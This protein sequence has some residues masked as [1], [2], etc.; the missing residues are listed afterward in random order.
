MFCNVTSLWTVMSHSNRRNSAQDEAGTPGGPD[1]LL[2]TWHAACDVATLSYT[3]GYITSVVKE[4]NK[5]DSCVYMYKC[6]GVLGRNP[7][8]L[9]QFLII[10][11]R[12]ISHYAVY[13]H[14][15]NSRKSDF[16]H[17]CKRAPPEIF[18]IDFV[19]PANLKAFRNQK[20]AVIVLVHFGSM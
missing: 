12:P 7:G 16:Y 2:S 20:N 11:S 13:V 4:R 9:I 5:S 8:V 10:N 17:E 15:N 14:L 1:W 18:W 19:A 6:F 3:W